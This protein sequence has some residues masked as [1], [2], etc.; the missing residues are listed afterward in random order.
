MRQVPIVSVVM[1]VYNA[2]KYLEEAIDSILSQTYK[3]F[4]FIIINDGS[5]DY[6][7]EIIKKYKKQDE[8]IVV[9]SRENK[10]LIVSLN[11]GIEKAKGKYIARMDADDISLPT[12]FEE[13]INLMSKENLDI[14]GCHY[15]VMNK[16]KK[17]IDTILTP[18]DNASLVLYLAFAVPFA[19]GSVMIKK[20]FL[21]ENNI[22]YGQKVDFAE[23]KALWIQLYETEAKF[24]NVNKILFEYREFNESLSKRK[25]KKLKI[26]NQNLKLNFIL[27]NYDDI[28]KSVRYLATSMESLS[29]REKEHLADM[30]LLLFIK[31]KKIVFVKFFK[32]IPARF[33]MIAIFKYCSNFFNFV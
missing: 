27:E 6:S 26:D 32:L 17:Y 12:R 13:Q 20:S 1:S 9:I 29:N 4:E 2:E 16:E 14:C 28:F 23:D 21:L 22:L 18:L 7:L 5:T 11:E 31:N 24:G 8:R 25:Y 19:H 33:K 15:F 3:D 30:L 10:G